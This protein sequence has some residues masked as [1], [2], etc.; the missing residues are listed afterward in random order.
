M[1][2]ID[3]FLFNYYQ[4]RLYISKTNSN[5]NTKAI[6]GKLRTFDKLFDIRGKSNLEFLFDTNLNIHKDQMNLPRYFYF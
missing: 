6:Q 4:I 3:F 2:I 1:I 5:Q